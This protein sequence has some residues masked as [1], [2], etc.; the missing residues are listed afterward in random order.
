MEMRE[1]T[2]LKWY[3]KIGYGSGDIA[4]NV[5]YALLSAFVMIF[6]TDTVGMNAG[7]I[8]SLIAAS[9]LLDGVSDI[10]LLDCKIK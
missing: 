6:L 10:F 8:G 3:N 1:K 5:I 4:G 2:Y 7:I 9:K